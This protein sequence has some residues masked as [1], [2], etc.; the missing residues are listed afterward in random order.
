LT[1]P[2]GNSSSTFT[3]VL[4]SNPLGSKRDIFGFEDVDG[5]NIEVVGGTVNPVPEI[6]FCGLVG[7]TCDI[8]Q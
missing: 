7:G 2:L 4:A 8:I 5:L 6:S 1:Y 3:F